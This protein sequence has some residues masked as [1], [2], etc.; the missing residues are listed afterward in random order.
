MCGEQR[1]HILEETNDG[2]KP[3]IISKQSHSGRDERRHKASDNFKTHFGRDERRQEANYY[4][5]VFYYR[6]NLSGS[7]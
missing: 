1:N 4:L 7:S 2:K 6:T 5:T 3:V